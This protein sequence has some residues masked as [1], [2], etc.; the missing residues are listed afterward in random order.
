MPDQCV[1]TLALDERHQVAAVLVAVF[2]V[3]LPVA[4]E[5]LLVSSF[6]A[7]LNP[8]LLEQLTLFLTAFGS[9]FPS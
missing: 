7:R 8:T 5:Q 3:T 4:V 9:V 6:W 2:S 1:A